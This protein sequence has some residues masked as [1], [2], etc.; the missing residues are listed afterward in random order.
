M[1]RRQ[2]CLIG[3]CLL[4]GKCLSLQRISVS[5]TRN[6]TKAGARPAAL[7][8]AREPCARKKIPSKLVR[9]MQSR[10][11][12]QEKDE[13][14]RNPLNT[15]KRIRASHQQMH[16]VCLCFEGPS[17]LPMDFGV[18]QS[19]TEFDFGN[20]VLLWVQPGVNS[21]PLSF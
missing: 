1:K 6:F 10:R 20:V 15:C 21:S 18:D 13:P 19:S 16:P 14:V 5:V 12:A 2:M 7:P 11:K 17:S 3:G 8:C 9:L 4:H